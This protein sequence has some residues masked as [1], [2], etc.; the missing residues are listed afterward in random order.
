MY[1]VRDDLYNTKRPHKSHASHYHRYFMFYSMSSFSL[2]FILREKFLTK[3]PFPDMTPR[4]TMKLSYHMH[5]LS[6]QYGY[7]N[8]FTIDTMKSSV[9]EKL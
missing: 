6:I 3:Y 2:F 8:P 9:L 4:D 1:R 5:F 7:L